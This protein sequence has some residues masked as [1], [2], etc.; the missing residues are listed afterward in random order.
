MQLQNLSL[1]CLHRRKKSIL[2]DRKSTTKKLCDKDFAERSDE[3]SG[4]ICL[5]TLVLLD[6]DR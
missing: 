2:E 1:F 4:A 6:N 5:K 3:L